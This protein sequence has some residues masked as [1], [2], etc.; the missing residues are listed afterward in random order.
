MGRDRVRGQNY[1]STQDDGK[2]DVHYIQKG[3]WGDI[4]YNVT[5]W[6]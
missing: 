4:G 6:Y 1:S 2:K 3:G 5:V